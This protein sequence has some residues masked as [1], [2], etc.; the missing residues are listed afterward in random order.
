MRRLLVFTIT[1]LMIV[2]AVSLAKSVDKSRFNQPSQRVD[3]DVFEMNPADQMPVIPYTGVDDPSMFGTTYYDFSNY[4]SLSKMIARDSMEGIQLVWT[5][6]YDA[7]VASRHVHYNYLS[8]LGWGFNNGSPVWALQRSGFDNMDIAGDGRAVVCCH[9]TIG[10][11]TFTTVGIDFLYEIG[12]FTPITVQN[13][14]GLTQCYWPHAA[15]DINDKCYVIGRVHPDVL[16]VDWTQMY[17]AESEDIATSFSPTFTQYQFADTVNVPSFTV[18]TSRIS[19][20]A[21]IGYHQFLGDYRNYGLWSG[22]LAS[23]VNNDAFFI[24]KERDEDWNW[25]NPVNITKTVVGDASYLPDS[26]QARGDTLRA[27]LDIELLFDNDDVLHAMFTT[28]GLWETPWDPA[29]ALDG[30]SEASFIWHWREDTD[31][32]NVVANGWWSVWDEMGV[33]DCGAWTSTIAR[34][35]MGIDAEGNI[36]CAYQQFADG[37][38]PGTIDLSQSGFANGDIM[39]TVSTDGGY[40]WAEPT[41][42]TNTRSNGAGPGDCFSEVFPSLVEEIGDSIQ[43]RYM[44]DKDAG[45]WVFDEGVSTENPMWYVSIPKA[46]I[47]TT[48]LIEQFYYHV[49]YVTPEPYILSAEGCTDLTPV[50]FEF[51][52]NYPNPFNPTTTFNFSLQRQADIKLNVYDVQGRLVAKLADGTYF[53]GKH[54]VEWDASEASSGVYFCKLTADG[55]TKTVKALLLK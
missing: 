10:T 31:S 43:L 28:R 6:G 52:G 21:A 40:N 18:A 7:A 8:A 12:A 45:S 1:V 46:D 4:G 53:S 19:D 13:P 30:L 32:L 3:V 29:S 35:S 26:V 54:S 41:N 2:S 47:P 42:I 50:E 27:Y 33:G 5:N 48:P 36:Y 49:R 15:M 44:E 24:R 39:V 37:S 20:R 25:D 23:Q 16:P 11:E 51:E 9:S 34:P 14:A 17:F 55:N 38:D 22:L